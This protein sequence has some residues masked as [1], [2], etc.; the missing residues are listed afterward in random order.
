[1]PAGKIVF[2]KFPREIRGMLFGNEIFGGSRAVIA[3]ASADDLLHR[4]SVEINARAE[5]AVHL[6]QVS[7]PVLLADLSPWPQ[8]LQVEA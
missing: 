1:M 7:D 4:T 8:S 3:E 2:A 5:S 6:Q